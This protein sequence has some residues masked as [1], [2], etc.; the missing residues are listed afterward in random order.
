M[1]SV[2]NLIPPA[3]APGQ[4]AAG[5]V[6]PAVELMAIPVTTRQ[7]AVGVV[8]PAAAVNESVNTT[9]VPNANQ[10]FDETTNLTAGAAN[11]PVGEVTTTTTT[12]TNGANRPVVSETT[13]AGGSALAQPVT[14]TMGTGIPS[15]Q[16]TV[17]SST[18]PSQTAAATTLP[19]TATMAPQSTVQAPSVPYAAP[20]TTMP[21]GLGAS[22]VAPA[23]QP[24]PYGT[25]PIAQYPSYTS[26]SGMSYGNGY[27]GTSTM[28]YPGYLSQAPLYVSRRRRHGYY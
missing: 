10:S 7:P 19:T 13:N 5:Q 1:T 6:A 24:V 18:I 25:M 11:Q 27:P 16:A 12:T 4:Q 22:A 3:A 9:A 21:L 15:N 2:S 26:G 14:S 28:G 8:N 23:T 20:A 17:G